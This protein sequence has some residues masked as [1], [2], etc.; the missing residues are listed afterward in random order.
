MN[1]LASGSLFSP[2]ELQPKIR[3]RRAPMPIVPKQVVFGPEP[4]RAG[5]S[6]TQ[7]AQRMRVESHERFRL[8]V[9][10]AIHAKLGLFLHRDQ[11]EML[12]CPLHRITL[13]TEA[14]RCGGSGV[15]TI[16]EQ[17][18]HYEG[19]LAFMWSLTPKPKPRR[20]VERFTVP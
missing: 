5:E 6:A 4:R 10:D 15:M 9:C 14:C 17:K 7:R 13:C 20:Q 16:G 11:D 1:Q 18:K 12:R 3:R 19:L 8:D 2:A